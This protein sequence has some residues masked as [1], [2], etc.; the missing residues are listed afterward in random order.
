VKIRQSEKPEYK[1]SI[2]SWGVTLE[3]PLGLFVVMI[4]G[5]RCFSIGGVYTDRILDHAG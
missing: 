2:Y 3:G 4:E 5:K 1:Q